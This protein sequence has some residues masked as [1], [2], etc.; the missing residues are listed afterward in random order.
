MKRSRLF[1][2]ALLAPLWTVGCGGSDDPAAADMASAPATV[3]DTA[4]LAQ[5]APAGQPSDAATDARGMGA[6]IAPRLTTPWTAEALQASQPLPEYP[7]P[8]LTRQEWL[9]LNGKWHYQGGAAAP[10]ADNAPDTAPAFPANPEKIRVPYPAESYLSGIQRSGERNLWYR[11]SF[12]VPHG[13][14]GKHV[15]LNF[16]AVDRKA[17]VYVNGK[18]VG[19]HIGGYDAFSFDITPYL[20]AGSNELVV[21]AYDATSND[22]TVGK[23]SNTPGGIFYTP[24][25]GIW[26]TVWLEP[27]AA[28]HVTRLDTTPDLSNNTLRVTVRGEGIPA[29]Q[30]ITV[31]AYDGTKYVG[32]GSGKVDQEFSIKIP[33]AHR[34]S[35]EDPFLYGLKA[36]INNGQIVDVVGSYF[37]MRSI[38]VGTV[39]GVPRPLLNGKFVFQH[40]PLDQGFWPDGLYTAPTDEALKSD[41]VAI[42]E[43]GFN[44]VRKHIKIEPQRWFYWADKLGLLVWQDMPHAWD[45]E[46][47]AAVRAEV[48]REDHEIVDEH[49]SSPSVVTWVIFNESWGDFDM[50]R[51][52]GT[53]KEWDASRL[54]N[55]HSGINFAP[56]DSGAGDLIDVHSYPGPSTPAFQPGRPA[57]L[58]EYGGNGLR[59]E[60]H[61]WNPAVTCCYTLY[62]DAAAL[63]QVFTGQISLLREQA[64]TQGLSAAVYTEITDVEDELNGFLTYDRQVKKLDFAA[65]RAANEQ[66]L[67]GVPFVRTGGSYSLRS[68]ATD[69][70]DRFLSH[71]AALTSIAG[72]AADSTDLAKQAA[73]WKLSPGLGDANCLSFESIDQPGQFLLAQATITVASYANSDVFRNDATF[74]PHK[75]LNGG[76]GF[77]FESKSHPGSYLRQQNSAVALGTETGDAG[78]RADASWLL[79][80]GFWR[81]TVALPVGEWHSLRVLTPNYDTRYVRHASGLLNTQVVNASSDDTLKAD[82]TWRIVKGLADSSCYS[83]ESKNFPGEYMRHA[84]S[85]VRRGALE[86]SELFR[87]DATFCTS[88]GTVGVRLAAFNYPD[89]FVRHYAEEL[90][91]ADGRGS[92]WN[93]AGGLE[94]DSNWAIESPWAP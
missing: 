37:G 74:C 17:T 7:R 58:G 82:A 5:P 2:A 12:E 27:V 63:T 94:I 40:G 46:S 59:V 69:A 73:S 49:R 68:V 34:W 44:M 8:Q 53:F 60:G 4:P 88:Q 64:S 16:G 10:S 50:A 65:V 92:D 19:Q 76:T 32:H 39:D 36:E 33:A 66:L 29:N 14:G 21:G 93:S 3:A 38:S 24:T 83:L 43:L 48:E 81:S 56:G 87:Q 30:S 52:A 80:P 1:Y 61:M 77:S 89:R 28:A 91:I 67:N 18:K 78:F 86:D 45:A 31:T 85:R 13:W 57:V 22:G 23:Q 35:P 54:I 42:K 20:R 75:A 90:W 62:P 71:N 70:T 9:N 41:L 51:M 79:V 72:V 47:D 15:K 84:Y 6:T 11:R 25:S 26:Q 55:T